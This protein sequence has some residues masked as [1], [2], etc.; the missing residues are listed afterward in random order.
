MR[1]KKLKTMTVLYP[2]PNKSKYITVH[3]PNLE[4]DITK[5]TEATIEVP[6]FGKAFIAENAKQYAAAI[7]QATKI[8]NE[9]NRK[10]E[11]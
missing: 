1:I 4:R 6:D 7:L 5:Q 11:T 8:A 9:Y 2:F 3:K 10:I